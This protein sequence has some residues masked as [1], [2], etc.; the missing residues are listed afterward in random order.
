MGTRNILNGATVISMVM[1]AL[2]TMGGCSTSEPTP[3]DLAR[4]NGYISRKAELASARAKGNAIND[5]HIQQAYEWSM[6]KQ[7]SVDGALSETG[8]LKE[9]CKSD[10]VAMPYFSGEDGTMSFIPMDNTTCEHT[11]NY[12]M[13]YKPDGELPYFDRM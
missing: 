1:T 13:K 7:E 10:I 11:W 6:D 9:G 3:D 8:S 4:S 12:T 2:L 5:E